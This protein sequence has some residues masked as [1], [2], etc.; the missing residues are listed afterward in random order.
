[1]FLILPVPVYWRM[2]KGRESLAREKVFFTHPLTTF[3]QIA[4]KV[5]HVIEPF[6]VPNYF[7]V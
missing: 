6:F 4:Y 5:K 2:H 3:D 1:M 7:L